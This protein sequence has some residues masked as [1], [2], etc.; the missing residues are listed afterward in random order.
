MDEFIPVSASLPETPQRQVSASGGKSP[1]KSV[2]GRS[3]KPDSGSVFA[4]NY[5]RRTMRA[6]PVRDGELTQ[7]VWVGT[8]TAVC[9]SITTLFFG[10]AVSIEQGL[11][12]SG[13]I[14]QHVKDYWLRLEMILFFLSFIFCGAEI[15]FAVL[16]H[17]RRNQIKNDTWFDDD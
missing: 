14:P 11:D 5:G 13:N 17:G 9:Y 7:L 15:S 8:L 16:G 3:R 2:S 10:Y 12:F 6:Y 1:K 4:V